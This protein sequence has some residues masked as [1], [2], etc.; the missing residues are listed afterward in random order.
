MKKIHL[1]SAAAVLSFAIGA[2]V[3]GAVTARAGDN[4][5]SLGIGVSNVLDNSDT[6]D[7][8][9]EY[10]MGEPFILGAKGFAGVEGTTDGSLYGLGGILWD[11]PI[12]PHLYFTPGLGAGLY[13]EGDDKDLGHVIEFRGQLELGY[14]FSSQDRVS[15]SLSHTSNAGLSDENPGTEALNVYYHMPISRIIGH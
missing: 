8:R 7:F 4:T 6:T 13:H 1:R 14:E 9:A 10:R 15:A 5:L 3:L 12:S 2:C 11:M